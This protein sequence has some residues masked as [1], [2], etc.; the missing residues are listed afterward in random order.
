MAT[1]DELIKGLEVLIQEARRIAADLSEQQW[2]H[3]VDPDGWR[4]KEVLAHVAGIGAIVVP[5]V[6][7]LA[8]APAERDIT[9]GNDLDAMNAG[10]VIARSGKSA[11]EL[12][13]EVARNYSA[14]IEYVRTAPDE[15]LQKHATMGG[16][17][18]MPISD[19]LMRAIVLHGIGHIY[20]VYSSIYFAPA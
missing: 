8:S 1:K 3:V 2:E 7:A 4:N 17:K 5:L 20:S 13:G 14:I 15:T 16:H 6:A 11:A 9:T 10:I 12:A 19:L 18:D